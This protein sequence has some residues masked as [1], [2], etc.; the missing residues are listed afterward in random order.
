MCN[1]I[2][3]TLVKHLGVSIIYNLSLLQKL[4]GGKSRYGILRAIKGL[5][6]WKDQK[7]PAYLTP[8][9]LLI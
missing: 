3:V 5:I 7:T 1:H 9:V 4:K 6:D 8:L 2:L